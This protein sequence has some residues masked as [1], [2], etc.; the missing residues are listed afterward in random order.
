[1]RFRFAA[2]AAVLTCAVLAPGVPAGHAAAAGSLAVGAAVTAYTPYCGPDGT[3]AANNCAAAPAG[4]VDPASTCLPAG[5]TLFTGRRLFAFEEP[6]TDQMG[7]GH[8]DAGDPYLD[9]NADG[10]WDG[11]FLGLSDRHP[12]QGCGLPP[13]IVEF[14]VSRCLFH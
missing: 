7:S 14:L 1:M 2:V 5:A 9:C 4:F 6:Y 10:R 12:K 13:E 11:N 8:Y 3:A